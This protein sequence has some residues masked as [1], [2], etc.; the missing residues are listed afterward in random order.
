MIER[1]REAQAE[2]WISRL[3]LGEAIAAGE[4]IGL[5]PGESFSTTLSAGAEWLR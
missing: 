3:P 4:A 5:G 1:E 2:P